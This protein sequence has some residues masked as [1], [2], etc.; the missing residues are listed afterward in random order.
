M[1]NACNTSNSFVLLGMVET[2]GSRFLYCVLCILTYSFTLFFSLTLAFVIWA[3]QSLHEPMYILIASLV[4]NGILGSSTF[5][6]KMMI[7]LLTRSNCISRVGCFTQAFC[8]GAFPISE[9]CIFT[10]MAYD[11]YLAVCHPLR[12]P[13]LMTKET[14]LYLLVSCSIVN[15]ISVLIAILLSARLPLCGTQINSIVCDNM[16]LVFL[17][18]VDNS[19]N[20]FYGTVLFSAYLIVCML[21]ICYSYLQISL[22]CLRLTSETYKRSVHTLVTHILNF[23]VFF[24][25]VLFVFIRY[26]VGRKN[27]AVLSAL[28]CLT[29]LVLPPFLNPLIYGM[30]TK[31][32]NA[33]VLCCLKKIN[34]GAFHKF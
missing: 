30:R 18:C 7:D 31:K 22:V 5:V 17:S 12:Y 25:G 6:P 23:S 14:V 8:I 16:G 33:K 9:I 29:T 20:Y 32:L 2:E 27:S 11:T 15:Y 34:K 10:I 28:L 3:E 24:I 4:L 21:L 13:T 1:D 26:R 19:I